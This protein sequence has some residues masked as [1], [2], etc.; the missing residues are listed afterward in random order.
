MLTKPVTFVWWVGTGSAI[1]RGTEPSAAWCST[2]STPRQAS[3]QAAGSTMLASMK[4]CWRHACGP[5]ACSTCSR[6]AR[7]PVAKL[8]SPTTCWPQRSRCST[9]CEPMKPALPVTSQARLRAPRRSFRRES[10]IGATRRNRVRVRLILYVRVH[11]VRRKLREQRVER[12]AAVLVVRDRRHDGRGLRQLLPFREAD[13]VLVLGLLR[14][15][16]R[17]VHV[18]LGAEGLQLAHHVYHARVA[19][20]GHVFLERE[21]EHDDVFLV[22]AEAAQDHALHGLLGDVLAHAVVDLAPREDHLRVVPQRLG[23][24]GEIVRIDA[25]A[26]SA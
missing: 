1:E 14:A 26:V 21:P 23:L 10:I 13:A 15:G 8:S 17:V 16:D 11:S 12:P 9:S 4:R 5:T 20:V 18:D 22:D 7:C 24:V 6:L 2:M 19:G 25:D 3:R